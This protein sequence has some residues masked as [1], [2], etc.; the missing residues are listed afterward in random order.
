MKTA[1]ADHAFSWVPPKTKEFIARFDTEMERLGYT[2]GQAIQN[3]YCWGK[4]VGCRTK[5]FLANLISPGGV[6]LTCHSTAMARSFALP[7]K[8]I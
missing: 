4:A 2:S 6:K 1:L 8:M 3:G 5:C 7:D